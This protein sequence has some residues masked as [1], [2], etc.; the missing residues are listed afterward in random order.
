MIG[1]PAG[2]GTLSHSTAGT[3]FN[4]QEALYRR[5]I[6][7]QFSCVASAEV[8]TARN[9]LAQVFLDSPSDVFIGIDDDVAVDIDLAL[10][11]LSRQ[12]NFVGTYLP[13]RV[14]DLNAFADNVR[15]GMDNSAAQLAAAPLV[16]PASDQQGVFE[17]DR[18][19]TGFYILRKP[20]LHTI[21]EKGLAVKQ[22]CT[23]PGFQM[24]LYGFFNNIIGADGGIT[25]EDYSFCDR[26]RAAGYS[27][28]AYKGPGISHTGSMT[29]RSG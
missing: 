29:F 26:V 22:Q 12:L 10:E 3:V 16:G 14:L 4:L 20:V 18:I 27:V 24:P 15:K 8:V 17:S 23:L 13:Q 28:F 19:G 11:L 1:V 6:G 2:R 5:N 9:I 25:S 7:V 21:A